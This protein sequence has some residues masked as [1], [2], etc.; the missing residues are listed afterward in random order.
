MK[1]QTLEQKKRSCKHSSSF[2]TT[3]FA[4]FGAIAENK[5]N[6]NGVTIFLEL[7]L[8]Y[9]SLMNSILVVDDDDD[10]LESVTFVLERN[11]FDVI[12]LSDCRKIIEV[13][14][15]KKPDL[16]LLDIN[17]GHCDGRQLCLQL[18]NKWRFPKHIL[19]F[20]ANPELVE[21][22][23]LYKADEFIRK[24]FS[25]KEFVHTIREHMPVN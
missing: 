14:A 3:S 12:A 1:S 20:S 9:Y 6:T 25:I 18:K 23:D 13:A 8:T 7:Y 24:P 21:S 15:Y 22:I 5:K 11:G 17:L 19:L 4:E 2:C 16:I 10:I